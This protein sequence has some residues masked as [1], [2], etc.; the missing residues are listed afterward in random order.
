[1]GNAQNKSG[2]RG[3]FFS[4]QEAP[5]RRHDNDSFHHKLTIETPRSATHF[6]QNPL[7]KHQNSI[8]RKNSEIMGGIPRAFRSSKLVNEWLY[9]GTVLRLV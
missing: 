9:F 3:I 5:A 6:S 2:M 8:A 7:Q 4:L 1:M